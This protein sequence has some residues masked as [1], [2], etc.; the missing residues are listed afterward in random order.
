[1]WFNTPN[2]TVLRDINSWAIR[3]LASAAFVSCLVSGFISCNTARSAVSNLLTLTHLS[4]SMVTWNFKQKGTTQLA[5]IFLPTHIPRIIYVGIPHVPRIICMGTWW[6]FPPNYVGITCKKGHF[7]TATHVYPTH[8]CPRIICAYLP[9]H[10]MRGEYVFFPL[11]H[12]F[13]LET[14][15]YYTWANPTVGMPTHN[16]RI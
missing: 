5:Q 6:E 9:T 8:I 7:G 3:T 4:S 10:K 15:A 14:H 13:P 12:L 16:M 11:S 1:M 2:W